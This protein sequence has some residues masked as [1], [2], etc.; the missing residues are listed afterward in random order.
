MENKK[1]GVETCIR[2]QTGNLAEASVKTTTEDSKQEPVVEPKQHLKNAAQNKNHAKA[3]PDPPKDGKA[4]PTKN[5]ANLG[6]CCRDLHAAL[7]PSYYRRIRNNSQVMQQARRKHTIV[8]LSLPP[9]S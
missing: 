4:R 7:N 3:G 8:G 5:I 2:A 1:M 6:L 9:T